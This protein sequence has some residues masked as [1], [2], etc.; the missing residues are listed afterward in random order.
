MRI[1][2]I[3][4][5]IVLIALGVWVALGDAH[6]NDNST[7]AQLGPIK[8]EA[9]TQKQ[10]PAGVGYAGIVIGGVLVAVGALKKK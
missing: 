5:G 3:L 7:K 8:V 4:V 1:A 6:Y 2:A 10:V 9:S